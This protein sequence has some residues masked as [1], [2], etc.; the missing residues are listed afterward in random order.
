[1]M[2]SLTFLA[3]EGVQKSGIRMKHTGQPFI[4]SNLVFAV[5]SLCTTVWPEPI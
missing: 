5:L 2:S 1:M 4:F 3:L